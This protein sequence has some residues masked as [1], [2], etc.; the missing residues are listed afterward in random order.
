MK[1]ICTAETG[2]WARS[3]KSASVPVIIHNLSSESKIADVV[4][5]YRNLK[6]R[7]VKL[8]YRNFTCYTK[9]DT[10]KGSPTIS[11]IPFKIPIYIDGRKSSQNT[12][13][14]FPDVEYANTSN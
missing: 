7:K 11:P 10:S 4:L 6:S 14:M 5:G 12:T 3:A 2:K 9:H 13:V 8:G 1:A